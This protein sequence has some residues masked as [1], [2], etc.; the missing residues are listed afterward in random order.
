MRKWIALFSSYRNST[1]INLRLILYPKTRQLY[2]RFWKTFFVWGFLFAR[3]SWLPVIHQHG[4]VVFLHK[5]VL[6]DYWLYLLVTVLNLIILAHLSGKVV[7]KRIACSALWSLINGKMADLKTASL[8]A[9]TFPAGDL[10]KLL[11]FSTFS[12]PVFQ[13][14]LHTPAEFPTIIILVHQLFSHSRRAKQN[15]PFLHCIDK[16]IGNN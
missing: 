12:S 14:H 5:A 1:T 16:V 10:P 13:I 11:P 3:Y 8:I 9:G 15:E 7:W 4:V 6:F 2:Y